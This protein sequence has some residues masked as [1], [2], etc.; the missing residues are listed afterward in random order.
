[1]R[2]WLATG[3]AFGGGVVIAIALVMFGLGAT[4]TLGPSTSGSSS[5]AGS[6]P[7][8]TPAPVPRATSTAPTA[9]Q[10]AATDAALA[11]TA[12]APVAPFDVTTQ[13]N[14]ALPA[15]MPA[16]ER[17][18]AHGAMQTHA[19]VALCMQDAGF[20]YTYTMWWSHAPTPGIFE[21]WVMSLPETEQAGADLALYGDTGAGADYHWDDAG[22]W[23]N[24]VHVMGND[25][26]H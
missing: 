21:S 20:D 5:A 15:D 19:I 17:L 3:I 4:N 10:P 25:N 9:K 14:Y 18:R 22:C 11:E 16:D 7:P 6:G 8:W 13:E 24:A 2:R 23:G 26:A 1:M 12:D